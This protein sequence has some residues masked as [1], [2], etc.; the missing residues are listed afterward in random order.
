MG[1]FVFHAD[2]NCGAEPIFQRYVLRRNFF[3][4]IIFSSPSRHLILVFDPP[5]PQGEGF[6]TGTLA[7]NSCLLHPHCKA[8]HHGFSLRPTMKSQQEKEK[9]WEEKL[10][11]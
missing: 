4:L 8:M 3:Y 6:L 2:S 11:N 7:Q 10:N 1:A 5:S 9:N